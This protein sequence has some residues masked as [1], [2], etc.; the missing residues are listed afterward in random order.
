MAIAR[1]MTAGFLVAICLAATNYFLP[2][3]PEAAEYQSINTNMQAIIHSGCSGWESGELIGNAVLLPSE[4]CPVLAVR[5][6][7]NGSLIS[8]PIEVAAGTTALG[9]HWVVD[10]AGR[11]L[12]NLSFRY[13]PDDSQWSKWYPLEV[14]SSNHQKDSQ[15]YT[16]LLASVAEPRYV[17]YR[18]VMDSSSRAPISLS[19]VKLFILNTSVQ[20]VD[21]FVWWFGRAIASATIKPPGIV[22]RRQWGANESLR[23]APD[24]SGV[25]SKTWPEEIEHL[26]KIVVHHTAGANICSSP[27][28]YCQRRSVI[29]INDI[30]YY[31]AVVNGWGDIGYNSLI[32]YDGRIYEGRVGQER[33]E[34]TEPLSAPVVAGHAL[35][36]NRRTHGVAVMGNFQQSPVPNIQ[37]ESLARLVGWVVKSKLATSGWVDPVAYADYRLSDGRIQAAL[38]NIVGHRDLDDTECPGDFLYQQ[39]QSLRYRAKRLV[40]WPPVHVELR[41][42]RQGETVAYHI[43]LDNHE[44]EIVQGLIV[45]GAIPAGSQYVDSWAGSPGNHRG[46]FDGSVVTWYDPLAK[47]TPGL[48]RREYVFII[49]PPPEVRLADVRTVAWAMIGGPTRGIAMSETVD[50]DAPLEIVVDDTGGGRLGYSGQWQESREGIGYHGATFH[51]RTSDVADGTFWWETTLPLAGKYE[52]Y[53]WWSESRTNLDVSNY[54]IYTKDGPRIVSTDQRQRGGEWVSLGVFDFDKGAVK[55]TLDGAAGGSLVAD[56]V[57]FRLQ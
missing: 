21:G 28:A 52:V 1:L 50:A 11:S 41:A 13:R 55:V 37:Y 9:A 36:Y 10:S 47:L 4:P 32:G 3:G 49:K 23:F 40:E 20:P 53:A 42:I 16:S 34:T 26:E 48:D 18:V 39:I 12:V 25:P 54:R 14:E 38:P 5:D 57:K 8:A 46:V 15:T 44:P 33:Q 2:V 6:A 56:A 27:E 24:E 43:L 45:K 51:T 31:H 29:A 19:S 30:Y 17:Q 7:G 35:G 22:S